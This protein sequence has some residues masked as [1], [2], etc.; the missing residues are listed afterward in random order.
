M[1]YNLIQFLEINFNF[2]NKIHCYNLNFNKKIE[3]LYKAI[4][5]NL[6]QSK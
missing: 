3:N 2:S 6:F 1:K 5:D 4:I